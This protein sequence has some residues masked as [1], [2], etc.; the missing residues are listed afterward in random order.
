MHD[1]R[2]IRENPERFDAQMARLGLSGVSSEVLAIDGARRAKIS[3]AEAALAERNAASK[4]VGA[5]KARGDEA[6]F[7]RLRGLVAEK[8]DE[9][10]RLEEEAKA[11]DQRLTDLLMGLPN[12]PLDEVPDGA[13][14]DDNVEI[15]RWGTPPAFSFTP[16]E[17]Y[18]L[19]AVKP[20][21]DFETAAK[22]SG[23]RFVVMRGAV[24]R[25]HRALAQ[26]MLDV[27]V[28]ENG[29]TETITPV[30]VRDE[31][32]LWHRTAAEVRRGQLSH[33]QWLVAD[34]DLG[35][36]ADQYGGGRDPGGGRSA[37]P[38]DRAYPVFPVGG[39][40]CGEGHC[41]HAASAPVREGGDGVDHPSRCLA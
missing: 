30:L 1:I 10:A 11:E 38:D 31:A 19:A 32:V 40:V 27:H 7:E 12:A 28:N 13:D 5:A 21:M 14:E 20:G 17:H 26:F 4:E 34:P 36:H 8:K 33:H 35:G 9:I 39:R 15:R 37:D 23:S 2:A 29:L 6:E 18:D 41:R 22:L 25:L 24:A 3:A 16:K